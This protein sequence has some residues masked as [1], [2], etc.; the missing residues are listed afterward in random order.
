MLSDGRTFHIR[1]FWHTSQP[2]PQAPV[3]DISAAR[4]GGDVMVLVVCRFVW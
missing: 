1:D 4:V 2:H 3:R